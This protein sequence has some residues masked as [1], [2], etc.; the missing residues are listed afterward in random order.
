MQSVKFTAFRL[1]F[2]N[3]LVCALFAGTA[4]AAMSDSEFI[5]LCERSSSEALFPGTMQQIIDAINN[6]ANVNARDEN[7]VTPLMIVVRAIVEFDPKIEEVINALV[8]AGADINAKSRT[9][10]TVAM[11][12]VISNSHP[13]VMKILIKSGVKADEKYPETGV[14]L[15]MLAARSNIHPEVPELI[16]TLVKS[17]ADVNAK[18][19]DGWTPL[20]Y[21]ARS[22]SD[23]CLEKVT[24]LLSLKADVH[25]KDKS[26]KTAIDHAREKEDLENTDVVRILEEAALKQKEQGRQSIFSGHGMLIVGGLLVFAIALLFITM[27]HS[28]K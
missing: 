19:K 13:E 27:K 18:D 11:F 12:A 7:G 14:T 10:M 5:D 1:V 9:G 22:L 15:L 4:F 2:L 8:K 6:G 3:L 24:T 23:F 26:G 28:R 16:K 25:A 17:G 20:I 21:A